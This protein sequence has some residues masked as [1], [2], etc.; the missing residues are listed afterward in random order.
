MRSPH[1]RRRAYSWSTVDP[2]A[3]DWPTG[4][5][6]RYGGWKAR[7]DLARIGWQGWLGLGLVVG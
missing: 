6:Y 3:E 4:E 5:R 7:E 1:E 2:V